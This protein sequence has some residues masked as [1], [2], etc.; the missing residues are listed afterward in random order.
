MM[1]GVWGDQPLPDFDDLVPF[2][3]SF[4]DDEKPPE[5]LITLVGEILEFRE[6]AT[7]SSCKYRE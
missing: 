7:V 1:F 4:N 2:V 6:G 5:W 3:R